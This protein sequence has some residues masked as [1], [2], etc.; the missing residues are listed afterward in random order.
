MDFSLFLQ[1]ALFF[2]VAFC[3]YLIAIASPIRKE[4]KK[5][6]HRTML[7]WIY[8]MGPF[9][10]VMAFSKMEL[11]RIC[12]FFLTLLTMQKACQE[13]TKRLLMPHD[14]NRFLAISSTMSLLCATFA[15]YTFILMPHIA[16]LLAMAFAIW[17]IRFEN[18]WAEIGQ[19]LLAW[20]WLIFPISTFV[21][22]ALSP[23]GT[24]NLIAL[25]LTVA[26]ANY[27]SE[28]M[29]IGGMELCGVPMEHTMGVL[30]DRWRIRLCEL[31][32]LCGSVIGAY[33]LL[34]CLLFIIP[35]VDEEEAILLSFVIGCTSYLGS[36]SLRLFIRVTDQTDPC[37]VNARGM[38]VLD[39]IAPFTFTNSAA[40]LLYTITA[41]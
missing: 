17:R 37:F 29:R 34:K 20:T 35:Q 38:H 30:K 41:N 22:I 25:G 31:M 26:T 21:L 33:L 32:G 12:A 1:L 4:Y 28:I 3:L 39:K 5:H 18:S 2:S 15:P 40:Y 7:R 9:L 14:F 36:A 16:L 13:Y 23:D 27:V 8:T 10:L 6:I 24:N 19:S 11:G